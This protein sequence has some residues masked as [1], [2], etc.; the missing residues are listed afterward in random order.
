VL[1]AALFMPGLVARR[2]REVHQQAM[3]VLELVRLSRWAHEFA[4]TLSGGQRK[5]LE[6]ARALMTEPR[7]ILLDEPMAGVA[8]TLALQLLE[9]V[10]ELR[11]TRNM[12]PLWNRGDWRVSV[13]RSG[14]GG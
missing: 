13:Q 11:A 3:Q 2:E 8:P 4:G 9:H 14:L 1:G 10:L 6:L 7:M 12:T 5:L